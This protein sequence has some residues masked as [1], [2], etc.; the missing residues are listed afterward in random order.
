MLFKSN[1]LLWR[2]AISLAGRM[3]NR[4]LWKAAILLVGRM[5]NR[6]L[7]KAAILVGRM[8][9]RA[10]WKVAGL[11]SGSVHNTAL[12]YSWLWLFSR[13]LSYSR[14]VGCIFNKCTVAVAYIPPIYTA[15]VYWP[16]LCRSTYT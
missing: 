1:E 12:I 5:V 14:E 10:L 6:A 15:W 13:V 11:R 2:V 9:N 3:V 7:W 16:H 4:A 8:V